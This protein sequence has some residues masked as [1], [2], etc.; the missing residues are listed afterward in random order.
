M[1][2]TFLDSQV[3]GHEQQVAAAEP[4]AAGSTRGPR[5]D[6]AA[7]EPGLPTGSAAGAELALANTAEPAACAQPAQRARRSDKPEPAPAEHAVA[8]KMRFDADPAE[9]PAAGARK[10]A[11]KGAKR[12]RAGA[13]G[14]AKGANKSA[15]RPSTRRA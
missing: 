5:A 12:G 9:P 11:A 7:A 4:A 1:P 2:Q 6:V 13:G 14:D 3:P 10:P 8:K 15:A